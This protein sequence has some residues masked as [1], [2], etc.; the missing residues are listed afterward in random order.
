MIKRGL[1]IFQIACFCCHLATV[2][3]KNMAVSGSIPQTLSVPNSTL[4]WDVTDHSNQSRDLSDWPDT[5]FSIGLEI[6]VYYEISGN[7]D[8]FISELM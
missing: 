6:R 5:N 3:I 8:K 1:S 4:R 7:E 2:D